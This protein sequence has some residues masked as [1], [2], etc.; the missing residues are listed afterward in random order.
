MMDSEDKKEDIFPDNIKNPVPLKPV[1]AFFF[2][3]SMLLI[4]VVGIITFVLQFLPINFFNI[5]IVKNK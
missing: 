2:Y 5:K 3:F 1:K 4:I